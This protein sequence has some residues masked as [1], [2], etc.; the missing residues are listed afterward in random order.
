MMQGDASWKAVTAC[1]CPTTHFLPSGITSL[2][3]TQRKDILSDIFPKVGLCVCGW[4]GRGVEGG[5][6]GTWLAGA[7]VRAAD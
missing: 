6:G 1:A 5:G 4:V 3:E 7:V 2:D